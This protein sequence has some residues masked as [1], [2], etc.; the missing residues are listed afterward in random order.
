M[1]EIFLCLT[2]VSMIVVTASSYAQQF[3]TISAVQ[4]VMATNTNQQW[5]LQK[6]KSQL[7]KL[8]PHAMRHRSVSSRPVS[9][10]RH[11]LR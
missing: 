1:K 10:R 7:S 6:H 9:T 5:M 3:K 2:L 8:V 11:G 4:R